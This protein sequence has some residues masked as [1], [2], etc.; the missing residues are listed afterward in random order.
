MADLLSKLALVDALEAFK[1]NKDP[2][3]FQK[4]LRE[5]VWCCGQ[6]TIQPYRPHDFS[7]HLFYAALNLLLF[8]VP[9]IGWIVMSWTMDAWLN[10]HGNDGFDILEANFS[11]FMREKATLDLLVKIAPPMLPEASAPPAERQ[12]SLLGSQSLFPSVAIA[13]NKQTVEGIPIASLIN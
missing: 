11:V 1:Q 7:T 10:P 12:P 8:C 9:I 5:I 3:L 6:N 13:V 4:T 2:V